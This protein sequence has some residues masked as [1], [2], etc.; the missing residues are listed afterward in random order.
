[1]PS[2]IVSKN[3]MD[4]PVPALSLPPVLNRMQDP[5][6]QPVNLIKLLSTLFKH[7]WKI[8]CF[9]LLAVIA[10]PIFYSFIPMRYQASATLMVTLGREHIKPN[11]GDDPNISR[12]ILADAIRTEMTIL[13]SPEV[14]DAA[15]SQIGPKTLFQRASR[16]LPDVLQP[17]FGWMKGSEIPL[18]EKPFDRM[19]PEFSRLILRSMVDVQNPKNSNFMIVMANHADPMVSAKIVNT[20]VQAYKAKRLEILSSDERARSFLN[21]KIDEYGQKVTVAEGKLEAWRK[22]HPDYV[23]VD[24]KPALLQQRANLEFSIQEAQIQG[25]QL[26]Q[27]IIGLEQEIKTIPKTLSS[28]GAVQTNREVDLKLLELR[29]KEQE[30]LS[31][32]REDSPF[33]TSV[34]REIAL[35]QEY[36][37]KLNSTE[38]VSSENSIYQS[39]QK[40]LLN[41]RSE[42]RAQEVRQ[43]ETEIYIQ[44]LN[45]KIQ[46]IEMIEEPYRELQQEV[47]LSRKALAS[48]QQK[49]ESIQVSEELNEKGLTS[50][51]VL[52][53][54]AVPLVPYSPK[55]PLSYYWLLAAFMGLFGGIG[56]AFVLEFYRQGIST[57]QQAEKLIELPVL[58]TI[59]Y[60]RRSSMA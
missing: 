47:A 22:A 30:M 7:R 40:D 5:E 34:R 19:P 45:R 55:R 51:N 3:R 49:K 38:N 29:R 31:K 11:L 14:L 41:L 16:S 24:Q 32:Y 53:E 26:Q 46:R 25:K 60:K 13:T 37:N 4:A 42:V 27:K 58:C 28:A 35:V 8:I 48:Y 17:V 9:F 18:E 50:I 52:E 15:V 54:A 56:I 6:M 43:R 21:E 12:P 23:L 20:L 33:V 57:P 1:M 10:T 2:H 36:L 59:G 44:E 39:L